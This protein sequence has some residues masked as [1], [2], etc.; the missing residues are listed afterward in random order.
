MNPIF[1]T[2][3]R[4]R[5]RLLLF[6]RVPQP[7]Q[8]KTR[9]A[10]TIGEDRALAL[11][12]AML[13]DTL[14]RIETLPESVEVEVAWTAHGA[15]SGDELRKTFGDHSLSMQAGADLGE[16]LIV[17][18]SERFL[19]H[20]AE[21]I[22]AIGVDDPS[23][24]AS[25]LEAAFALL[26]S[27]DWVIGPAVDGGY[28]L[29][30]CRAESFA[31]EVFRQI[32]WGGADVFAATLRRIEEQNAT[33]SILPRR[34]DIDLAEDLTNSAAVVSQRVGSLLKEWGFVA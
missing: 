2:T 3:R 34:C 30:G 27:C 7:G 17:A 8:V 23:I 25:L 6:A 12:R 14:E 20:R 24:P 5:Q 26:D 4:P 31:P 19:F 18:F 29:I 15:V 28:Y 11:Y 10:A 32:E 22:V 9:L 1:P 16:R 21:K 33:V 13:E